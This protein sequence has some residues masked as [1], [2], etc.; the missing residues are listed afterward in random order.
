MKYKGI[1]ADGHINEP[2][3]LWTSRLPAKFKE[4]GPHV[5]ETPNTHGH[6]WMME[7]QTRPSP[8]GFSSVNY[9]SAKRYD[10]SNI[11]EKFKTV[12]DRGVR[13]EDLFPGSWDPIARVKE[14]TEDGTDAE[15][16]FN[17]VQTVWNGL[18]LMPDHELALACYQAYNDWIAEFQRAA[19]ERLIANGTIPT[20]GIEDALS[21][22]YRC[23]ELGLRTVQLEAYPSGSFFEPLPEDD[24][25]WAAAV[26]IGMPINVH[27]SFFFA[28]GDLAA[29]K[30]SATNAQAVDRVNAMS[31]FGIDLDA[32]KFQ[33]IMAKMIL[34]GVFDRHP[35]F[36][37]VGTE[38]WIGWLPHYLEQ[39]DESVRRNR[40]LPEG[41]ELKML[42]SEYF[43][44]N[45][46]VVY[47]TDEAGALNRYDV[48]V[49]NIMWGP[50]F[51]HSASSW[52]ID[53]EI[54]LEILERAGC[55]QSEIDRIMWKNCADL[56]GL[57]YE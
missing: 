10:R 55:T 43:K 48:G 9:R 11:I 54:G 12:K 15:V 5:I 39:F 22:L 24:R 27:T 7:G 14:M 38:V 45:V 46:M 25:F 49:G 40:H 47:I 33:A 31:R 51:P 36:K 18:K 23:K 4:R 41:T 3:D 29:G 28:T 42:P 20:T 35:D 19:L 26:E 21:E 50:D 16:L 44:R 53:Y 32:G 37:L 6:A 17:G 52:P 30:P 1:S 57:E 56:Y 2:P 8:M 34:S 13:Y